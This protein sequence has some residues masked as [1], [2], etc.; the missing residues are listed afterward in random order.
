MWEEHLDRR[1]DA[2]FSSSLDPING[3]LGRLRRAGGLGGRFREEFDG[4]VV[5]ETYKKRL[6]DCYVRKQEKEIE[7][8]KL[9]E[10]EGREGA[11]EKHA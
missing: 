6:E 7:E 11:T 9:R 10:I 2:R 3:S 1:L 5:I 4:G 8:G